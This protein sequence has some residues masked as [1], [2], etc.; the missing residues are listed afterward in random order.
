M[1]HMKFLLEFE[2]NKNQIPINY[3]RLF[4]HFLKSCV[5]SANDGKYYDKYYDGTST[6]N[7]TFAVFMDKPTFESD[8]ILLNSNRIKLLFST[9]DKMTGF[10]FYSSFLEKKYKKYPMAEE[11]FMI[12]KNVTK[13]NEE[14]ITSEKMLVKMNSPLVIRK[15][16]K[17]KNKDFY[18]SYEQEEFEKIAKEVINHQ[19]EKEGFSKE[20]RETFSVIPVKCRKVI[21]KH[22]S[23]KIEATLG[24]LLLEGNPAVLKYLLQAG[25]GSRKSEGFGMMELLTQNV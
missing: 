12:L 13:L 7:F 22:Y 1:T 18:Y 19:L 15:H 16:E 14:N 4:I 17:D 21:V 6:K 25:M 5:N 2:L 24:N 9:S 8:K 3:H 10:I 23:C 20:Y 11:N